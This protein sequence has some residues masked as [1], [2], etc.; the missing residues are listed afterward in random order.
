MR[1]YRVIEKRN[2]YYPEYK[3]GWKTFWC[4]TSLTR[5]AY[6]QYPK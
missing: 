3:N 5:P 4:W 2:K 6:E 1:E